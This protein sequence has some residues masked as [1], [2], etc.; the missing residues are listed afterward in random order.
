MNDSLSGRV[1]LLA[2]V[3]IT[4]FPVVIGALVLAG[5]N[6]ELSSTER[7]IFGPLS[8]LVGVSMA[9]GLVLSRGSPRLG[10]GLVAVGVVW[11]TEPGK[12]QETSI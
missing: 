11:A 9:T 6:G 2:A 12:A 8:L 5:L 7:A 1:I 3:A 4:L 10:L